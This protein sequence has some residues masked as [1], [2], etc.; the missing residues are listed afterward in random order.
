MINFIGWLVLLVALAYALWM[1]YHEI[2]MDR[3]TK[4]FRKGIDRLSK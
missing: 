3:E 4:R 1:S 2:K